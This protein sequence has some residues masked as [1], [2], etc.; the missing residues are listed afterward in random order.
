VAEAVRR[1]DA[2]Q[3]D[4]SSGVECAPGRKDPALIRAF[5]EAARAA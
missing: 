5:V 4:V 3:L 2:R 1:S